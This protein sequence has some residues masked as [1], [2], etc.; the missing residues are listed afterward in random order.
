MSF[1]C[2]SYEKGKA[3]HNQKTQ[4]DS[5]HFSAKD[6]VKQFTLGRIFHLLDEL[7]SDFHT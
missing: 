1:V 4:A 7:L 2:R 6:R 5:E 3:K